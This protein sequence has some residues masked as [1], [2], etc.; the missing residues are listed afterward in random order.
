MSKDDIQFLTTDSWKV[1]TDHLQGKYQLLPTASRFE[2]V[3]SYFFTIG[4]FIL[5]L[6]ILAVII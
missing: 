6:T 1:V 3:A 4:E 2:L 5:T